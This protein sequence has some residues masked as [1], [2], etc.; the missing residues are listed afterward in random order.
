[1]FET[2]T[3]RK[4]ATAA[5]EGMMPA[6]SAGRP[7][8]SAGGALPVQCKLAI[9]AVND[10]MELEAEAMADRVMRMPDTPV[11]SRADSAGKNTAPQAAF[12]QRKCAQCE[13]EKVQRQPLTPFVQRQAQG[14]AHAGGA[15]SASIHAAQGNG[16]T[17]DTTTLGFMESRFATD[18]SSVKIHTGGEAEGFSRQLNA[19]AF[20]VGNDIYFNSGKYNPASAE[21]KHLLAHELTHTLQQSGTSGTMVQ[22]MLVCPLRLN[23]SDPVPAGFKPYFGNAHVFHCG[24]RGIL[25]DRRPTPGDPMNECFYDHSGTLVTESH[26]FAGC[27]GTPDYYDSQT[28]SYNHFA[29]DPGGVVQAGGPALLESIKYPIL[30]PLMDLG[31]YLERNIRRLYGVP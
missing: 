18:F 13:E 29:N 17:M 12:V 28:D 5:P 1:M 30:S 6:A 7:D 26:P 16:F 8:Y 10:P 2:T 22:R 20:T 21:G 25:E 23:D 11:H 15:L 9:G 24:F 14:N 3:G 31:G 19:Q 27:R 4:I